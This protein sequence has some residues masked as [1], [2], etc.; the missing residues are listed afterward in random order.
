[1]ILIG[2]NVV[3]INVDDPLSVKLWARIT[4]KVLHSSG[5]LKVWLSSV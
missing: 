5:G 2:Y 3:K 4:K 1:M